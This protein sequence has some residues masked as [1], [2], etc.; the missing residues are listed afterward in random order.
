LAT[1][2]LQPPRSLPSR[3]LLQ[4]ALLFL[5]LHLHLQPSTLT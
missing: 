1:S 5:L 2:P 4:S 3:K